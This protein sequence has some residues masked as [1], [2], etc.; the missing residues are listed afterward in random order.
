MQFVQGACSQL[1]GGE[2]DDD[3]EVVRVMMI[4]RW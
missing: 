4:G 3:W 2:G 1:G